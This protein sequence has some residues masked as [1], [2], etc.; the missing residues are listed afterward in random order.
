MRRDSAADPEDWHEYIRAAERKIAIARHHLDRLGEQPAQEPEP[1]IAE[2]AY[3]EGVINAFVSA[4]EQAAGAI[5][6]ARHGSGNAGSLSALLEH[7][8]TSNTTMRLTAWNKDTLVR[9]VRSVRNRAA[10]RYYKK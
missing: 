6:V 9:D 7:I 2:Q 10:H 1:S 8:P 3:F 5:H 4:T